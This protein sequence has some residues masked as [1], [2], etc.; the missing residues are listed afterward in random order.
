MGNTSAQEQAAAALAKLA[1]DSAD[2]RTSIVDKG[3]INPLLALLEGSS[4]KAKEASVFAISELAYKSHHIQVAIS[5]A[6]GIPLLANVLS[7]SGANPKEMQA[8]QLLCS[9]A[10]NAVSQLT[11]NNNENQVAFAEAGAIQPLV[12]MLGSSSPEYPL[13][14]NAAGALAALSHDNAENQAAVA[15]T[16][17]I[18]PL[19][20][21]VREGADSDVK[22]QSASA[23]WAL[24]HENNPNKATV[25]KLGGIEPLVT[26]LIAGESERSFEM[27]VGAL[28][29]LCSKHADNREIIAKLIVV[30]VSSR[31]AMVQTPG[32][33]VRVLSSVSKL[34]AGN[35]SN[36]MALA[37]AGAVQWLITWLSGTIDGNT[38]GGLNVEAQCEAANALLAMAANNEPIQ[39]QIHRTAGIAPLIELLSKGTP[40]AQAAAIK[41]L[42][43]LASS[44]ESATAI[45]A[46]GGLPPMC[47]M[48]SSEDVQAQELAAIVISR[49]LKS[50]S[51]VTLTVAEVGGIVPLVNLLRHGSP[52]GQQQAACAIAEIGLTPAN[53]DL[54]ADAGGINALVALLTSN[55]VGTPE[56]AGRALAHLSRNESET[57][58]DGGAPPEAVDEKAAVD[59]KLALGASRRRLI[60]QAGGV[61]RLVDMLQSVSLSGTITARKM[62]ELVSKVI[63]A[64][65]NEESNSKGRKDAKDGEDGLA[66]KSSFEVTEVIWSLQ[67]QA[68]AT[69][70]EFVYGDV[71]MQ[72]AMIEAGSVP[73]LLLLTRNGSVTAQEHSA[74]AIWHLCAATDNHGMIVD[75]GAI[76]ELVALSKVGSARAQELAAAV[77]S[78]LAK[79]A[80]LEREQIM[81]RREKEMQETAKAL[82]QPIPPKPSSFEEEG[83]VKET[84]MTGD[85]VKAPAPSAEDEEDIFAGDRLSA[86]AAAGGVIPLVGLVT[87]GNQMG[88]ERAASALWH[89]S[90]DVVNQVAIAKAGGIP[91]IVQLLDDGTKQAHE[92]AVA[93][94]ARLST[95]NPENQAQIAKKLV[96]LLGHPDEGAQTR[97]AHA[98][99]DLAENN[100]GAPVRIVN[101]G[102]ISPLVALLGTGSIEAKEEAV[103]AL[104]CLAHNDPSNQLAIATGLVALLGSGTAEAQEQVTQM[105]IKFAQHPDNRTAIAEA[106]AVQRLIV[107]LRGGGETSLKAQEL[108][109][110]VLAHLSGDSQVHVAAI[111]SFGGIKPLVS[112]LV[113]EST[114][115]Q[116]RCAAVL[117][118]MTRS[119][120]EIQTTV[121]KEGAIDHLV[122][123][124]EPVD[125]AGTGGSLEGRSE[126]AAALWSISTTNTETTNKIAELGAI[127]KIVRLLHEKDVPAQK[128]AAGAL[129][130]LARGGGK[131]ENNS[132]PIQ[133]DIAKGDAIKPLVALLGSKH[134]DDVHARMAEA[135]AELARGHNLNQTAVS[136]VGGIELLVKLLK[137]DGAEH[138]KAAAA[139]AL[140]SFSTKHA[141]NQKRVA[142]AGGLSPLVEL[143][144]LGNQETQHFAAGALAS[145]A[146]DNPQNE[147]T[148]ADMMTDL[149]ASD[150]PETC[151]KAARAISRLARAHPSNQVALA[152][153]GGLK[154]LVRMLADTLLEKVSTMSKSEV[155]I[156]V[157]L[158]KEISSALW[159]MAFNSGP[160]QEVIAAEGGVPSLITLLSNNRTE[161]H[162]DAAGALWSL[163][164]AP[165]NQELIAKS[166]G[167]VPLVA[168]LA[169][170]SPGAQETAAGA[171]RSLAAWPENRVAIAEANG[172]P[173]LVNLFETSIKEAKVEAAGA[174]STLVISNPANQS[175]VA[176]DL[177]AMLARSSSSTQTQEDVTDLLYNL[178]L[179]PENRGALSKWGA[180]P[181]LTRQLSEG[182]PSAQINAASALSQLALK[183]AQHRVQVTA[184]LIELLGSPEPSV[185]QRAWKALKDMAAEGGNDSTMTVQMAGGIDRF[186][187]LLKEGSLEA[188]EYALWLLWQS[189]DT[190]SKRSI[191]SV[192]CAKPIIAILRSGALSGVA[193]EHAASVLAGMTSHEHAAVDESARTMNKK[194]IVEAGGVPP[195]VD[196]LHSGSQG[197]KKHAALALAQ[198][199][200]SV[201]D[202]DSQVQVEI[203]QAGAI[204]ALVDWLNDPSLG[205]PAVAAR[206]LADLASSC[207]DTQASI[208]EASAIP[209]LVTMMVRGNIEGRKWAAGAVA[210]L[211]AGN[212]VNQIAIA[213][214][215][216][217]PPLVDLL[218]NQAVA[219]PHANATR[220][221]WHLSAL[222]ENQL[223]VA[224]E[225]ALPPLV[226]QLQSE[227]PSTQEWAA[228]AMQSL[229]QDCISNCLSLVKVGAIDPLVQ[230]LGSESAD[231][232]LYTQGALLNISLPN[233]ETRAAVVK[234]LVGL[235]E[236]RNATAQM[237]AAESLAML[238]SRS[239]ENRTVIAQAGAIPALITLL[240][241]GRNVGKSQIRA[242]ATICDLARVS[243]NK[244]AI[245]NAGGV[246]PLVTM[247]TSSSV[248]AQTRASGALWHLSSSTSAQGLIANASG[249]ELLVGLLTSERVAAANNAACALYHLAT[250]NINKEALVKVGSSSHA[251]NYCRP[252][253]LHIPVVRAGLAACAF[254]LLSLAY[255]HVCVMQA[256]GIVPLVNLLNRTQSS[257]AQDAVVALLADLARQNGVKATIVKSNGIK[258]LVGLLL[259]GSVTAQKHVACALWC[260]SSEPAFQNAVC[261]ENAVPALVKVLTTN[262]KARGYA[263]AALC[264]LAHDA[265]ARRQIIS[266]GGV[267][268]LMVI[269]TGPPSWLQ[270]QALGILTLLDIPIRKHPT[271]SGQSMSQAL[272]LKLSPA[273]SYF[274]QQEAERLQADREAKERGELTSRRTPRSS[275]GFDSC[276]HNPRFYSDAGDL[277]AEFQHLVDT[278]RLNKNSSYK[279]PDKV[280]PSLSPPKMR[281]DQTTKALDFDKPN[282]RVTQALGLPPPVATP[283]AVAFDL[284]SGAA[285]DEATAP[286]AP[287]SKKNGGATP[288]LVDVM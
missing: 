28:M 8:A 15:R 150:D 227:L 86:I 226:G 67:E 63:G 196:L 27:A 281:M 138:A 204:S 54:V 125:Q 240:G 228:A 37:K 245:V 254:D 112:L 278:P 158:Q 2:N 152:R 153:A 215:Q 10:A 90:V 31:I 187:K 263:T 102:A 249:I 175:S 128:N 33:G 87:N 84:E 99:W 155:R 286:P 5:R 69:I 182:T 20:A 1:S 53:R 262:E 276:N 58:D 135:L 106:G 103:G 11:E 264:N 233:K 18:A 273:K 195:I 207:A 148:I 94:L 232:Q 130:S 126:A 159:S 61:K 14:A 229:S 139:N 205:P 89:L 145:M 56:T 241:D 284:P 216:G 168:L 260:L 157:L 17:A 223:T 88:K 239:A 277:L 183:S 76:T 146:L 198:L 91:P 16:G 288:V 142:D 266:E 274:Q 45:E 164:A 269:S 47:S 62:W 70:S 170:G 51:S 171:I 234:P 191:A 122:N 143:L 101:A 259:T 120:T 42:W 211:A 222:P 124:L 144:G 74:R 104:T 172:V 235:L 57:P 129:A 133:E 92:H 50:N 39:S 40:A 208:M 64:S 243:E 109:A 134:H 140:W 35:L 141:G 29:S 199:S 180:I 162:R 220:A 272:A 184:Q 149:L 96:G 283:P 280:R 25:A 267:D 247:L 265:E 13:V 261:N 238:A 275:R 270:S 118:D 231:T 49:L 121:A 221:L 189:P 38:K 83:T 111:A 7:S 113:S 218:K 256:G 136:E 68:A 32:G 46:A 22:E 206:A 188:Q 212:V 93:A 279:S 203:A 178:T 201:E 176:H 115:A 108:A 34:C 80:I 179:T 117:A 160:N 257:E 131:G 23:L 100:D 285:Q 213:E 44:S 71:E 98:L 66:K 107:Q 194:D 167:I 123:L 26:L 192:G 116:A 72:D 21:L 137:S 161:V 55:V 186:V 85:D 119:S 251:A 230:L 147:S 246:Q 165:S 77:I 73:P 255:A 166:G 258:G 253:P 19:C 209:P 224:R 81:I 36:Q 287:D 174:L 132:K 225:G 48:L 9:L 151:T 154:K 282:A 185:R 177:V 202:H 59:A 193:Q 114:K 190:A 248:E 173:A 250:N 43:H 197:A 6:G 60:H 210:A 156:H 105:L 217:I 24:S 181:Q 163:G 252:T 78:D 110:S 242:A 127:P 52:A 236:V 169:G 200:R 219:G 82:G 95:N 3:G 79:G 4:L 271:G 12:A 41:S 30:R 65:P 237:K 75:C 97:S 214:E 244:Q 268:P